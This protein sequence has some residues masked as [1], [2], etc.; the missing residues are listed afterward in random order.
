MIFLTDQSIVSFVPADRS[1]IAISTGLDAILTGPKTPHAGIFYVTET[2]A[3]EL[4]YFDLAIVGLA[5]ADPGARE[6]VALDEWGSVRLIR[7]DG[8]FEEGFYPKRGPM[9]HLRRVDGQL[10][11]S[12][13]GAQV[14]RRDHDGV[15][16]EFGPPVDEHPEHRLSIIESIDGFASDDLYGAA[17]QGVIWWYKAGRWRAVHC[18]TNLAFYD[19]QCADDGLVYACGQ[20]GVLAVGREDRFTLIAPESRLADL[21][22]IAR[23]DGKVYAASMRSLLELRDGSLVP[24]MPAMDVAATFFGL[25]AADG[26]LWSVGQKDVIRFDGTDWAPIGEP[27]WVM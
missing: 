7:D 8:I 17:N 13:T 1:R 2:E 12:G 27:E 19:I 6:L 5:F 11:A 24:C 4:A 9:R 25:R 26:V 18:A 15:W 14:F 10:L 23:F 22:G 20:L 21:W 16:R 3:R